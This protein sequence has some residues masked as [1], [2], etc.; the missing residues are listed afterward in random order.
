MID[1]IYSYQ[2]INNENLLIGTNYCHFRNGKLSSTFTYNFDFLKDSH[3]YHIDPELSFIKSQGQHVE[4]LPRCF[5]DSAPDR[6]GRNLIIKRKQAETGRIPT[7]DDRDFLLGVS[8]E[9]RQGALRF[10]LE[11][12]G[13]FQH[14][15][16][17]VPKLLEL[18]KL[19]HAAQQVSKQGVEAH[20]AIKELLDAGSGSLGGARPKA[21]VYDGNKLMLAKFPH[22]HDEW[23]MMAWEQ[24]AL[25][26]AKIARIKVPHSKLVTI[27]NQSVLLLERFDRKSTERIGYMS[28]MTMLEANDGDSKDYLELADEMPVY[29]E[30]TKQNLQ[31]LL[32][33]IIFS[34]AINNTDDH[35][36]NHGFLRTKKA[37]ELSPIFDINPNPSTEA[38][39]ATTIAGASTASDEF[40]ALREN[41][42]MFDV[43][44]AL[45]KEIVHDI[46]SAVSQWEKVAKKNGIKDKEIKTFEPM[47][48]QRLVLLK[49]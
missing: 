15:E 3:F 23:N 35:L 37:W 48:T 27:E 2:S 10:S 1:K 39:R 32:R 49:E 19:M 21:S 30:D 13:E 43:S 45:F 33:R 31:E 6:W 28:A 5:M 16:T 4:N 42:A 24:T 41:I 18:P 36:R 14:P 34:I 9:T 17:H 38:H 22:H 26:L 20:E 8:D 25:D 11:E 7:L 12:N 29:M 44:S 46:H 40:K 47:F